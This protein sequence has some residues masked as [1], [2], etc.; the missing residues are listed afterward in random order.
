MN[1]ITELRKFITEMP[2]GHIL[3]GLMVPGSDEQ[4]WEVD[5]WVGVTVEQPISLPTGSTAA[6]RLLRALWRSGY[7]YAPNSPVDTG[8]GGWTSYVWSVPLTV[9]QCLEWYSD[10]ETFTA[11]I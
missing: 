4:R 3:G 8:S 6:E 10:G 5:H 2:G 11:H 1:D 7:L 9:A